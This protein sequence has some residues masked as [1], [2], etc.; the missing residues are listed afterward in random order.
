M[1]VTEYYV[2]SSHQ[3]DLGGRLVAPRS[4]VTLT[5]EEQDRPEVKTLIKRKILIE[6]SQPRKSAAKPKE[7]D[8]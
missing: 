3:E 7:G 6:P 5:D 1:T 8:S 4:V 2:S